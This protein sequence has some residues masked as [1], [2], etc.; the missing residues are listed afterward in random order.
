[1]AL[2]PNFTA[3]QSSGTPSTITLTDTSTGSDAAI[4]QRRVYLL[5]ADGT[6]LVVSGTTTDYEAWAY[7][8][9]TI[10]LDVLSQ[11]TAL[12]ITV[13]WLD[14]GNV[15]LY[16]KTIAYGFSAYGETFY[17]GLTQ[18]QVPIQNPAV[19]LSTNYYQNK[20]KFRV[21]L[22]SADQAISF[23]SDIYSAS[24][25]YDASTEMIANKAFYF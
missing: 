21:F 15:V 25:C 16:T 24:V 12:S 2:T 19:A 14:S 11:D 13:Q 4:T 9:S 22:D 18:S 3:S 23:A 7:A 20:M 5:Q 17:Y 10:S 1:M 6:Y 8:S